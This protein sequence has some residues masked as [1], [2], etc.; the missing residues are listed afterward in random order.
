[1]RSDVII[2]GAGASGLTAAIFAARSGASVRILEHKES[3]GKKLLL[4]GNGK[5]NLSNQVMDPSLY[6]GAEP[7]FVTSVL[8]TYGKEQ[9][10]SFFREI[11]V[12]I[13]ERNGY[14]YPQNEE[15]SG[16]LRALLLEC[17]RCGVS[18]DYEIGIKKILPQTDG[19]C[20]ETKQGAF[21]SRS[22]V[23][24]TGGCSRKETGSDGSGF[25]YLAA[26]SHTTQDI[27]PS[28]IQLKA[29]ASFLKATAGI[30]ADTS[31]T[32]YIDETPAATEAGELQMTEDGVSGIAV[33]QLS[34]YAAVA[35]KEGK[36]VSLVVDFLP[37]S[38]D[39]DAVAAMYQ[40]LFD[41]NPADLSLLL[42]GSV[43]RKLIPVVLEQCA[44]PDKPGAQVTKEEM[45]RLANCLKAFAFPIIGTRK[46]NDAQVTAGGVDTR[47]VDRETLGSKKTPGLYFCGEM[48]D[49][50][51]PCG[52][53][54]L[55]WAWSSGMCAGKHAGE[56]SLSAKE[57]HS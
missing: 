37:A 5:C 12:L 56:Y 36:N 28:L 35:L 40:K 1:M 4:T 55:Q 19:F 2:V 49:V 18:I 24:A 57:L 34:R 16:V 13:R 46:L 43:H 48:L 15:A 42:A 25:L 53:Y 54:N 3:A 39:A 11:G 52:G 20:L 45:A 10:I 41:G 22:C 38:G 44:V 23:L 7:G 29:K 50:D 26:L 31:L 33:F 30:R 6:R 17:E 14:L 8:E 9:T 47:E 51:G 21:F 32:L 27:V